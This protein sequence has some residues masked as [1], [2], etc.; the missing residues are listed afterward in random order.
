MNV[1]SDSPIPTPFNDRRT[2]LVLFG[3]LE[4]LL[5]GL[6]LLLVLLMFFGQAMQSRATG[7]APAY[8]FVLPAAAMYGIMAVVFVWLG[9]GSIQARRWARALS[10]ILSWSWLV[11]GLITVV[12]LM[13]LLP[14][15]LAASA[16]P[17]ANLPAGAQ[18]AI[19]VVT[20]GIVSVMFVI[21]PGSLL[22]FYRSP[23]VKAT[24]EARDPVVRWTEACPLPV[25]AL[26]LWLGFGA[27]SLLLMGVVYGGGLPC[28]G[29]L[30]SGVPGMVLSLGLAGLWA[31][32]AWSSFHLQA[33]AWWLTTGLLVLFGCSAWITFSRVDLLEMYRLMGYPEAQIEQM[34]RFNF[35]S[36]PA[37]AWWSLSAVLPMLGYLLWI[38]RFFR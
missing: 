17:G 16:P 26:C 11:V 14:R 7:V 4:I 22:L 37:F 20:L 36:G 8:R 19:M 30:I 21:L 1:P 33:R 29:I 12:F 35:F 38:K 13:V 34:R 10:L 15:T 2:G 24:C 9:I 31:Y 32:L 3:V 18:W 5:G 6:C 25:L 28:F 23:H 27:V